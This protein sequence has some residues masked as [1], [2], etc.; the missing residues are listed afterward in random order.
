MTITDPRALAEQVLDE[1]EMMTLQG[2]DVARET[3][4][5]RALLDALD[6]IDIA[7]DRIEQLEAS[8]D[9][10]TMWLV[11]VERI[12]DR[13]PPQAYFATEEAAQQAVALLTARYAD[14][15]F[16][17]EVNCVRYA[18]HTDAEFAFHTHDEDAP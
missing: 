15:Y 6:C 2:F 7:W 16:P 3:Q 8:L 14:D 4:L 5:A 10:K 9:R 11:S 13:H 12:G 1:N 17:A 18:L